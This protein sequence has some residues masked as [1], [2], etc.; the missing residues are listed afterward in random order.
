MS[1]TA[2]SKIEPVESPDKPPMGRPRSADVDRRI[3]KETLDVVSERGFSGV[4]VNEICERAGISRA[5]FYRRYPSPAEALA[6]AIN[7]AFE[8]HTPPHSDDPVEYLLEFARALERSYSDPR[9]APAIGFLIG[10]YNAKPDVYER[11]QQGL[12]ER[13][14]YVRGALEAVG[15]L[16]RQSELPLDLDEVLVILSS[17]AWN[18]AVTKR[19]L[20]PAVLRTVI[21]RLTGS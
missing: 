10:E 11:L 19:K 1:K 3:E 8:F 21:T 15:S 4:T 12:R 20:D 2:A 14:A 17:L 16:P 18:A 13:R 7:S 6:A 5:T 9:I